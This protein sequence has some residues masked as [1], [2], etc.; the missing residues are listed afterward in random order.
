E[1]VHG[2]S[3]TVFLPLAICHLILNRRRI[4]AKLRRRPVAA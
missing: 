2:I 3:G 1:R 4:A